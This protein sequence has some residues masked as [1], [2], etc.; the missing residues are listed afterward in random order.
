MKYKIVHTCRDCNLQSVLILDL[1]SDPNFLT[2]YLHDF[3][4]ECK[5]CFSIVSYFNVE[6]LNEREEREP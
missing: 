1:N 3:N 6:M 4:I 2:E 5:N